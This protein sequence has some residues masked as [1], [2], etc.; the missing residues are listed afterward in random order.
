[1][2][3]QRG[4]TRALL[5]AGGAL[6]SAAGCLVVSPLD[7]IPEREGRS[8][9]GDT[10]R[11][12]E[13]PLAGEAGQPSFGGSGN[14]TNECETNADCVRPAAGAAYRCRP[15]DHTC[16]PLY[17]DECPLV[18]GPSEH[19]RAIYFG[20]FATLNPVAPQK[21]TILWAHELARQELSGDNLGGLPGPDGSRPL[22]MIACN[23][24]EGMAEPA[25]EHLIEQVEVPAVIA[26]LKPGDLRRGF[27]AHRARD[28]FYLSPVAVTKTLIKADDADLIWNLLG[29]PSDL[30]PAYAELTRLSESY[31]RKSPAV[32]DGAP[33][34]AALITT[35]DAFDSELANSVRQVLEV[36]GVDLATNLEDDNYRDYTLDSVEELEEVSREVIAFRPHLIISAASELVTMPGGLL[37]QIEMSWGD[38][39]IPGD[40]MQRPFYL[41]SPYNAGDLG[42]VEKLINGFIDSGFETDP[43]QRF[44]GLSIANAENLTLQ[45]GYANRLRSDFPDAYTDSAN[46]YD[47][48]YFLAYA[49]FASSD[50]G[51]LTGPGIANGMRRLL[52]G[53]QRFDVGP[54]PIND[55]LDA[56]ETENSTIE[57]G[58]TLGPPGFEPDTGVRS[59]DGA[60]FCFKKEGATATR[61][62]DVLRYDRASGAYRGQSFPCF[63]GFFP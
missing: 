6:G 57:L 59:V 63:S 35:K 26:T 30:A 39:S 50:R 34:R 19:P 21:H 54:L 49:M 55:V 33:L 2:R 44:V 31:L 20:A 5:L 8:A 7:E 28:V 58:S 62:I 48:V 16:V 29:E 38:I 25:L 17:S 9:G 46:Y 37:Q 47:A 4:L 11:A 18:Y 32:A 3:A 14:S 10:S 23:N 36:N 27:E 1:M 24:D 45:N 42:N 41:L 52:S 61:R 43:Q 56:L 40:T 53:E 15:S 13:A 12:G 22:V 51:A 60:V